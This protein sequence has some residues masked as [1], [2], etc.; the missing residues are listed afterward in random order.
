M[1]IMQRYW[2]QTYQTH[3]VRGNQGPLQEL[4][5]CGGRQELGMGMRR[6]GGLWGGMMTGYVLVLVMGS[7]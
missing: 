3:L 2:G 5:G 7:E 6:G 4:L 1:H